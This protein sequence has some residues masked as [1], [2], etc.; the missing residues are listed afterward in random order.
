MRS[1]KKRQS[2]KVLFIATKSLKSVSVGS[3]LGCSLQHVRRLR[4]GAYT[5]F[6]RLGNSLGKANVYY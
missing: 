4:E 2:H 5:D 6:I 1:Q 3:A